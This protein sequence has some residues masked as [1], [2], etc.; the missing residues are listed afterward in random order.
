MYGDR[1][2]DTDTILPML[3]VARRRFTIRF[4]NDNSPTT[5][6][7]IVEAITDYE[8]QYKDTQRSDLRQAVN[9]SM[10]QKHILKL[11]ATDIVDYDDQSKAVMK[12]PKHQ[13]AMNILDYVETA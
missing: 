4:V 13:R 1:R 3:S 5:L 11:D 6:R 9:V 12:G 2:E 10:Y 7:D 8:I